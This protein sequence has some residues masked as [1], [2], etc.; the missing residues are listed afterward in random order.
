MPMQWLLTWAQNKN[1]LADL[2]RRREEYLLIGSKDKSA[3]IFAP[4][5]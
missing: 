5:I 4:I 3:T 2:H 1:S